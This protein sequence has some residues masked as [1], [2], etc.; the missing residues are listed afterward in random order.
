[1]N[2]PLFFKLL[3]SKESLQE[4]INQ[5]HIV[6]DGV[7]SNSNVVIQWVLPLSRGER[8]RHSGEAG[9]LRPSS[10]NCH[11]RRRFRRHLQGR[12]GDACCP[13]KSGSWRAVW[14]NYSVGGANVILQQ[15]AEWLRCVIRH[16]RV[17]GHHKNSK[18]RKI[19][20][21]SSHDINKKHGGWG[22]KR[23]LG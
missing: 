9:W 15:T 19:A 22:F 12:R 3:S 14:R 18:H 6:Q 10:A 23:K 20:H 16:L 1:M 8:R 11:W 17:L 2:A 21:I 7:E 13:V 4:V 5:S